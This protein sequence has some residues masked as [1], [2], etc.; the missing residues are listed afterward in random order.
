MFEGTHPR[1]VIEEPPPGSPGPDL[2]MVC[3]ARTLERNI[4][5]DPETYASV[6]EVLLGAAMQGK[7][8]LSGT[9]AQ[10]MATYDGPDG[11]VA[12]YFLHRH[13]RDVQYD[14]LTEDAL[15]TQSEHSSRVGQAKEAKAYT[16]S[17]GAMSHR[18]QPHAKAELLRDTA[19]VS[20]LAF[21]V[22]QVMEWGKA[23]GRLAS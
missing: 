23:H 1:F 16:V 2:E 15:A 6:L 20:R 19:R 8:D 21:Y 11:T 14:P 17:T 13:D 3:S 9:F 4:R 18:L 5:E 22:Y 10:A 12:K 7:L